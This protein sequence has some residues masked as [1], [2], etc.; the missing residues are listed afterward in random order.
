MHRILSNEFVYSDRNVLHIESILS[1][2][3]EGS[4]LFYIIYAGIHLNAISL[5]VYQIKYEALLKD[6]ISYKWPIN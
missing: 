3:I 1:H 6:K 4:L 5:N 2:L